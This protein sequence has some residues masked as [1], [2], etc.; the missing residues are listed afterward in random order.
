MA[1]AM[2]SD[3][4]QRDADVPAGV[5]GEQRRRTS[6]W[7]RRSRPTT[8][9]TRRRSSAGRRERRHPVQRRRLDVRRRAQPRQPH[10]AGLAGEQQPDHDDGPGDAPRTPAGSSAGA[11]AS[12]ARAARPARPAG[13]LGSSSVVVIAP[14]VHREGGPGASGPPS[15]SAS[16]CPS[17]VSSSTCS[18]FSAVTKP[19]PVSTGW[20]PPTVLRLSWYSVRKTIGR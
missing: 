7:C 13:P 6:P 14:L 4:Q 10:V 3:T 8:D 9:R 20:P 2:S 15:L 12:G 17:P 11:T 5:H 16:G 18:A 19:G 1:T